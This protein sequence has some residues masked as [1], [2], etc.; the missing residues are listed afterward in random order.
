MQSIASLVECLH[1]QL[2]SWS[3][4]RTLLHMLRGCI[5]P[6]RF[7]MH[8]PI[9]DMQPICTFWD[10]VVRHRVWFHAFI[11]Y[12]LNALYILGTV[13]SNGD[14]VVN[15]KDWVSGFMIWLSVS[16]LSYIFSLLL[17]SSVP[18]FFGVNQI[19]LILHF[20]SSVGILTA[21]PFIIFICFPSI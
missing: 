9:T 10:R 14:T 11:R 18:D 8:L 12:W 15:K 7:Q 20:N 17:C 2:S 16:L 6:C 21:L 13:E 5:P 19:F 3:V 1:T 4:G